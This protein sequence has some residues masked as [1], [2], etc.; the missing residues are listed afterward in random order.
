M[1]LAALVACVSPLAGWADDGPAPKERACLHH[2]DIALRLAFSPDG[3]LLASVG[4]DGGVRLWDPKDGRAVRVL[5]GQEGPTFVVAFASDG[6]SVA[7]GGEDGTVRLWD[8][9]SGKLLRRLEG[10]ARGVTALAFSPDGRTLAT[11]GY[12]RIA[13]LWDLPAGESRKLGEEGEMAYAALFSADGRSLAVGRKGSV[14]LWEVAT[15]RVAGRLEN[16]GPPVWSLALSPDGRTL[17]AAGTGANDSAALW[18]LATGR[19]RDSFR[20]P[21]G[22]DA[23]AFA[24]DGASLATGGSSGDVRLW[25][26]A[27]RKRQLLGWHFKEVTAVAFSP[28]GRTLA[29]A[30]WDS[31]VRL[32]DASAP[33]VTG[34]G[35]GPD[36]AA[37]RRFVADLGGEDAAK[38]YQAV[39]SL[40]R[41]PDQT[42]PLLKND[43]E[44][45]TAPGPKA[46]A[47][48]VARLI[49]DLDSDTFAVRDKAEKGLARLGGAARPALT[50]VLTKPNSADLRRRVEGL[51]AKLP[52]DFTLSPR[53]VRLVRCIEFLER[54][55]TPEARPLLEKLAEG[56]AGERVRQEAR[57]SLG[58]LGRK[59]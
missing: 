1:V 59:P 34:E 3:R 40:A 54:I 18:E 7:S 27:G 11:V 17:A 19:R 44:Q 16:R 9:A 43:V 4:R 50:A 25:D 12:D 38:A 49:A 14:W 22:V 52:D 55:G 56:A 46:E 5:G 29:S 42:L 45:A 53:D 57:G 36:A 48:L 20:G 8:P 23:V 31:T 24:P 15:G 21:A 6:K 58:R 33:A 39:L 32:W 28:D 51:L 2:K 41:S 35:K 26:A 47:D 10:H 30:S 37:A 13:R